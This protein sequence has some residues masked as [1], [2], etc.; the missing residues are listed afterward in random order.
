M[1]DFPSELR[2]Q[3]WKQAFGPGGAVQSA[4]GACGRAPAG[5]RAVAAL[6]AQRATSNAGSPMRCPRAL[7]AS[8]CS[9][10]HLRS[11]PVVLTCK[12]GPASP[13]AAAR[14]RA[15]DG[16]RAAAGGRQAA[17]RVGP[18]HPPAPA[19]GAAAALAAAVRRSQKADE[20]ERGRRVQGPAIQAAG[21]Q[22]HCSLLPTQGTAALLRGRQAAGPY[23][24]PRRMPAPRHQT[25]LYHAGLK[26]QQRRGHQRLI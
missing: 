16:A 9:S 15:A 13:A 26:A 23:R 3:L 22:V 17:A 4:G 6:A 2:K 19:V 7:V 18:A 1:P 25:S 5:S 20:L 14:P 8:P 10:W 21:R 24:Q 12:S 11:C